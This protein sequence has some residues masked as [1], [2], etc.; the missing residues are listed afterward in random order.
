MDSTLSYLQ[1]TTFS[2]LYDLGVPL[3]PSYVLS[4]LPYSFVGLLLLHVANK[5]TKQSQSRSGVGVVSSSPFLSLAKAEA[6][7]W[8][9]V[10]LTSHYSDVTNFGIPGPNV[11][12]DV[13]VAPL[14]GLLTV[15]SIKPFGKVL[16]TMPICAFYYVRAQ[17]RD[18]D[19]G[20]KIYDH[21]MWHW[22]GQTFRML[23]LLHHERRRAV[24][25]VERTRR[26]DDADKDKDE[27]GGAAVIPTMTTT[28]TT[29]WSPEFLLWVAATWSL[30]VL[31][32]SFKP[33]ADLG[34]GALCLM[35]LFGFAVMTIIRRDDDE[36]EEREKSG[37]ISSSAPQQ[38]TGRSLRRRPSRAAG[39]SSS[40]SS[41]SDSSDSSSTFLLRQLL[42][43]GDD[44]AREGEGLVMNASSSLQSAKIMSTSVEKVL[45]RR[46]R[47]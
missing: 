38:G 24:A 41:S 18:P 44:L 46:R 40:S 13:F 19:C 3:P 36:E 32:M 12:L 45:M 14:A 33:T 17:T 30:L 28:T 16:V 34:G 25:V 47:L 43:A 37:G 7:L 29:T 15:L 4:S 2:T 27:R 31:S 21:S 5:K 11:L 23:A 26:K 9:L 10:G 20:G 22:T 42:T 1:S 6:F 39:S 35:A 8:L